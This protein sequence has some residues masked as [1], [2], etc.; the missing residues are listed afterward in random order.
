ML[1]LPPDAAVQLEPAPELV[2][3]AGAEPIGSFAK[4]SLNSVPAD[5]GGGAW[6]GAG[7]DG[8]GFPVGLGLASGD[9][10]G[11]GVGDGPGPDD[12]GGGATAE[13]WFASHAL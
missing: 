8:V 11:V 4:L 10:D 2:Q 1:L 5:P 13:G 3:P 9:G 12:G 7:D 6:T